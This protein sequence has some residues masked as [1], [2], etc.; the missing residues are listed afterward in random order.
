[1][2]VRWWHGNTGGGS[3]RCSPLGGSALWRSELARNCAPLRIQIFA[4]PRPENCTGCSAR[5]P[6]RTRFARRT[7]PER[8]KGCCVSD[9]GSVLRFPDKAA[10]VTVH[11]W[12]SVVRRRR[13]SGIALHLTGLEKHTHVFTVQWSRN[14]AQT[15]VCPVCGT[16]GLKPQIAKITSV[17]EGWTIKVLRCPSCQARYADPLCAANYHEADR[18][19]LKFYLEQG[20]GI[21]T[22]L[23]SLNIADSRP[24]RHYLEVGCSFGFVMDYARRILGWHIRGFDPGFIAAAGKQQLQLPIENAYFAGLPPSEARA[25]LLLCSEVLEH[26]AEPRAFVIQLRGAL[27]P[28]GLL[29]LTT[30][31]G[32]A[33]TETLPQELLLPLLSPGQHVILYNTYAITVLLNQAG[34]RHVRTID[35]GHQLIIAASSV[36][37]EGK[38]LH[39]TPALY[40]QYLSKAAATHHIGTPLGAGLAYRLLKEETNLSRF[41]AAQSIYLR[42]RDAYLDHYGLDL[43]NFDLHIPARWDFREFSKRF[44]C[45]LT[46]VL[47]ARG[48][49]QLLHEDAPEKAAH[50]FSTAIRFGAALRARLRAIGADDAETA[51]LCREAEIARLRGLTRFDPE[52][53]VS[54]LKKLTFAQKCGESTTLLLHRRR[55]QRAVFADLVFLGHYEMAENALSSRHLAGSDGDN[56]DDFLPDF[57]WALYLLNYKDDAANAAATLSEVRER[58]ADLIALSCQKEG[59]ESQFQEIEIAWLA[60]LARSNAPEAALAFRQVLCNRVELDGAVLAAHGRRAFSRI[61]TDLVNLGNYAAAERVVA[62]WPD[63]VVVL[64]SQTAELGLAWGVY[65]LNHLGEFA[66]AAEVFGRVCECADG[67]LFWVARFN[68]GLAS[69]YLG[70]DVTAYAVAAEIRD[71]GPEK[72]PVPG[73]LLARVEE[74]I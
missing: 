31:N 59:I 16:G 33:L 15:S 35:T 18:H 10:R 30:P 5:K 60:A 13:W 65:L 57:A 56:P 39:F 8:K 2:S 17:T 34:F 41:G 20:A 4:A 66:T 40:Y 52:T 11:R 74:L 68:Q 51:A 19:G 32:D 6:S 22:M 37:F 49:I 26:I 58:V 50:T 71:P 9:R 36:G 55:A 29:L 48:L 43:D 73:H 72:A 47:Y 45:N 69:H 42:I 24:I 70:D 54:E 12:V 28:G 46:G 21:R 1:M 53:G 44:P 64:G 25:D 61:F 14:P 63:A 7:V 67:D 62:S 38:S 27:N 3:N 23:E